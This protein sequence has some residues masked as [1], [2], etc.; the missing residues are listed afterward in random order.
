MRSADPFLPAVS[1]VMP[2]RDAQATL[3]DCLHSIRAQ[4][5]TSWELVAVDDGSL[6]GT[7]ALLAEFADRDA[8]IHIEDSPG[9]GI[10]AAL[11]RGLSLARAPIVAR[12]DSDDW[13][14]PRRLAC[15]LRYLA[16][17]PE[18]D[19]VASRVCGFPLA[20]CSDGLQEYLRWQNACLTPEDMRG[21]IYVE[22]PVT[23]GSVAFRAHAVHELG[24]YREGPFPEDYDLW[25]R[26]V[27]SG[28]Q[29]AKMP[30]LLFHWRQHEGS[31]SRRDAR[32]ARAAFDRLR[33]DFLATDPRLSG[34]RSLVFWG[35]GRR[36]RKR[37]ERVRARCGQPA[38]WIDID[39]RKIGNR[40]QGIS[41]FGPEWLAK[42]SAQTSA[43]TSDKTSERPFVLVWVAN[44]GARDAIGSSLRSM[45]YARGLDYL[46]VG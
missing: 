44:H 28:R 4:T 40:L 43:K 33:G 23:H 42:T 10:V 22:A 30:E 31:H 14:D 17:H 32:Y 27:R 36:T 9:P 37:S 21:E 25:L 12:M 15:Q 13:M 2:V 41:V 11:N 35:A 8:R 29:M 26:F 5:E 19:L 34:A 45:G 20:R 16:D 1:I 24:G 38:A 39:P 18:I 3:R 46:M 6:D 7:R